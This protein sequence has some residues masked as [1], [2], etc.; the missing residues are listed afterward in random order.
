MGL[1]NLVI[2]KFHT[3]KRNIYLRMSHFLDDI[4]NNSSSNNT[5][6]REELV[7]I[8]NMRLNQVQTANSSVDN[9]LNFISQYKMVL[10]FMREIFQRS[11]VELINMTSDLNT[12]SVHQKFFHLWNDVVVYGKKV[13]GCI[14]GECD[15]EGYFDKSSKQY[16]QNTKKRMDVEY[17]VNSK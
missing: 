2:D 14:R 15:V 1:P 10:E 12:S 7:I 13:D 9:E 3:L 8:C 4:L 17:N 11:A 6:S 5:L 16:K